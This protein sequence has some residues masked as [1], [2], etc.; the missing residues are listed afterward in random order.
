M[1]FRDIMPAGRHVSHVDPCPYIAP[2]PVTDALHMTKIGSDFRGSIGTNTGV[3]QQTCLI[4]SK[5]CWWSGRHENGWLFEHIPANGPVYCVI[6]GKK[7]TRYWTRPR[8][9]CT[10]L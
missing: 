4:M 1:N 10:S 7:C 2:M 6:L 9:F 3:V 8:N 5:Q